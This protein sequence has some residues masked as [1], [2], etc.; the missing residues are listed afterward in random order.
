MAVSHGFVDGPKTPVWRSGLPGTTTAMPH[1]DTTPPAPRAVGRGTGEQ[2]KLSRA[3]GRH[4]PNTGSASYETKTGPGEPGEGRVW[5]LGA[6]VRH[7]WGQRGCGSGPRPA[8]M[9]G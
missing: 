7:C 1:P 4:Y 6:W 2:A 8:I 9:S 3:P 5:C